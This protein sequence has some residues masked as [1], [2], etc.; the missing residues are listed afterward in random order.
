MEISQTQSADLPFVIR[1]N[2][3]GKDQLKREA[4]LIG[5]DDLCPVCLQNHL[6][7][8]GLLNLEYNECG[9]TVGGCLS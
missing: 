7:Y 4:A 2:Q 8:N 3:Q 6:D 9:Y 5:R 1:I